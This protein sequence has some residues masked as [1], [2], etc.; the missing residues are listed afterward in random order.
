MSKPVNISTFAAVKTFC[1]TLK[2]LK[3]MKKLMY[4]ALAFIAIATGFATTPQ[5]KT[6]GLQSFP[7]EKKL[8]IRHLADSLFGV[9]YVDYDF[10]SCRLYFDTL[11]GMSDNGACSEIRIG[12]FVGRNLDEKINNDA[13][14][15]IKIKGNGN[16]KASIGVVGCFSEF[17]YNRAIHDTMPDKFYD[18]LPGR[19]VDGINEKGVYI[20]VNIV[21]KRIDVSN[22]GY[23]CVT[24]KP[25]IENAYNTLY[26]TRFVLDNADGVADA[27]K[28]IKERTWYFPRKYPIKDNEYQPFHWMIANKDTSCVLEMQADTIAVLLTTN[29]KAPS[30]CTIMTNFSNYLW[31]T[32]KYDPLG[33]GYERYE[34]LQ[35]RY[36]QLKNRSVTIADMFETMQNVWFSKSFTIPIY[37]KDF[38]MTELSSQLITSKYL[39]HNTELVKCPFF[40]TLMRQY[41]EQWM[42]ESWWFNDRT[43]LWYTIHT[44]VYDIENR[45]LMIMPH[46]GGKKKPTDKSND[47]FYKFKLGDPLR[48]SKYSIQKLNSKY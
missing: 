20:G 14:A 43:S 42:D 48:L 41:T 47:I 36:G 16:R 23:F 3:G 39:H 31:S 1:L 35:N 24:G 45:T 19:T 29:I 18:C 26:L 11:Y 13:C 38:W 33:I 5:Q 22:S 2:T 7:E 10:E 8:Q 32:D 34:I 27:I 30:P 44:S 40:E 15:V 46:E 4:L 25:D 21:P 9:E 17:S 37:D 6:T 12:N 28:K